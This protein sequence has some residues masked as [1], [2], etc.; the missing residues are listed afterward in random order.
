ML[1]SFILLGK[2]LELVARRKASDAVSKLMSLR[3]QY[4]AQEHAPHIAK[5]LYKSMPETAV[6]MH[7]WPST[8]EET[9]DVPIAQLQ[10]GDVCKIIR[11]SKAPADSIMVQG[12]AAF[13][14]SMLTG[15]SM[16][17]NKCTHLHNYC[18][19]QTL[20]CHAYVIV[21]MLLRFEVSSY[22]AHSQ[23]SSVIGGTIC[24]DGLA[25][26]RVTKTG[27]NSAL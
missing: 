11:G 3:Y 15:E 18:S 25:Y 27:N 5:R 16:P 13:D 26:C 10:Y 19:H 20:L 1:L 21:N 14:E 7:A 9:T 2:L 22:Y 17:V 4:G 6:V 24:C 23:G 8:V 12:T